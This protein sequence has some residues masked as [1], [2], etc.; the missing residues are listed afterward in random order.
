MSDTTTPQEREPKS[1]DYPNEFDYWENCA[2]YW[3]RR[4]ERA[5]RERDE[6]ARWR[7]EAVAN[8][9]KRQCSLRDRRLAELEAE[10]DAAQLRVKQLEQTI[11]V[12][13]AAVNTLDTTGRVL[14]AH[15]RAAAEK[16]RSESRPE[17]LESER[18]MNS[19][20]T[21]ENDRLTVELAECRRDA[22]RYRWLLEQP[23]GFEI[24]IRE[25][26]EDPDFE[27]GEWVSGHTPAEIDAAI[28]AAMAGETA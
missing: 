14:A 26:S 23:D 11:K 28:R 16:A 15:D 6:L 18:A 22:E 20:L 17:A 8:C 3:K 2:D 27:E 12:Q 5:E 10:R 13:A 9:A 25:P 24:T 1:Q 4:A 19:T 7:D 21:E